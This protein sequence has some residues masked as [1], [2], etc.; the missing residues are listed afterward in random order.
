[1]FSVRL[2]LIATALVAAGCS[3]QTT[4]YVERTLAA[5]TGNTKIRSTKTRRTKTRR[6]KSRR[7]KSRRTKIVNVVKSAS[8]DARPKTR[9]TIGR[10]RAGKR[11]V[12]IYRVNDKT[13]IR[14]NLGNGRSITKQL[15]PFLHKLGPAYRHHSETWIIDRDGD[16]QNWNDGDYLSAAK[17]AG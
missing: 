12:T 4:P 1:M 14:Q 3:V 17:P 6:T 13:F 2:P 8:V 7:T 11:P 15:K 5:L 16:L 10:W 9:T